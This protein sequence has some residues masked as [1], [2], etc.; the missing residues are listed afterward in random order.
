MLQ[1]EYYCNEV[2][3]P[4]LG[5]GKGKKNKSNH[6]TWTHDKEKFAHVFALHLLLAELDLYEW[7]HR[8]EELPPCP[9][10]H[11]A[12]LVD[13]LL[14]AA[15]RQILNLKAHMKDGSRQTGRH[16]TNRCIKGPVWTIEW[17]LVAVV[18]ELLGLRCV[19]ALVF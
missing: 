17:C 18:S 15:D 14:N 11:A 13:V 16:G 3:E 12:V 1:V 7:L 6:C 19:N 2:P 4:L 8:S 10:L 9:V 5:V